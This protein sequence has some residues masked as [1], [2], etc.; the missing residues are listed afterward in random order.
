MRDES[1]TDYQ[2]NV[3]TPALRGREA[4]HHNCLKPSAT[5]LK[6][7][8]ACYT[9]RIPSS[10]RFEPGLRF[11][12]FLLKRAHGVVI[13]RGF[14][15]ILF[16]KVACL[17]NFLLGIWWRL[18]DGFRAFASVFFGGKLSVLRC[19]CFILVLLVLRALLV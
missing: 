1:C 18:I 13:A 16:G 12:G 2:G 11:C 9:S 7:L 3:T 8:K 10:W 17:L 15:L 6:R 19:F 5:A 4:S 14:L